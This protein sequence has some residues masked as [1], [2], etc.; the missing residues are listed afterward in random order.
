M[1]LAMIKLEAHQNNQGKKKDGSSK[2]I[3]HKDYY[4][5]LDGGW[6]PF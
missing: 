6:K 1:E 4:P 3:D 2:F 5:I